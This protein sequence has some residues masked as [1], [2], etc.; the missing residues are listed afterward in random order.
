MEFKA[1]PLLIALPECGNRWPDAFPAER[2]NPWQRWIRP[3]DA[4]LRHAFA[5]EHRTPHII[6]AAYL[7]FLLALDAP[8]RQAVLSRTPDRRPL[9]AGDRRAGQACQQQLRAGYE[10]FHAQAAAA[11]GRGK[12]RACLDCRVLAPAEDGILLS[13]GNQ[14]D[15]TGA[16]R[17]GAGGLTC[18]ADLA[19][20]V[21]DLLAARFSDLPGKIALNQPFRERTLAAHYRR[22]PAPWLT[23]DLAPH[24]LLGN[25]G[26]VSQPRVQRL[27]ERLDAVLLLWCKLEG[28]LGDGAA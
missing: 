20:D 9:Y 3:A 21:R 22:Q 13:V 17:P 10:S 25:E 27:Q 2:K 11:L 4:A 15:V 16:A 6:G 8:L 24:L 1:L 14:G 12:I 5:L 19:R 7:P 26:Q 23:L 28:W 18:P